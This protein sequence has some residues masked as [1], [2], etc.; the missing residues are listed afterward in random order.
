MVAGLRQS[1]PQDV[2]QGRARPVVDLVHALFYH[3]G[4]PEGM[5]IVL[6]AVVRNV[7][8]KSTRIS[9]ARIHRGIVGRCCQRQVPILITIVHVNIVPSFISRPTAMQWLMNISYKVNKKH[10]A[11]SLQNVRCVGRTPLG[12]MD[13]MVGEVD[14]R[15]RD[16]GVVRTIPRIIEETLAIPAHPT[17]NVT[18]LL[19][20]VNVVQG[21][22]PVVGAGVPSDI[23]P[24]GHLRERTAVLPAVW[25]HAVGTFGENIE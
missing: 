4:V 2:L 5:K 10:E 16:T 14:N 13:Q 1:D 22:A 19:F 8:Y 24:V 17:L 25:V 11:R 3:K 15:S 9:L 23:G 7:G 21:R 6:F 18:G 20:N 12:G